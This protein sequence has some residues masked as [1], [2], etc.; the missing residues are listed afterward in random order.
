V[1]NITLTLPTLLLSILFLSACS[2][3]P[4]S[5]Q[6]TPQLDTNSI[7]AQVESEQKWLLDSQDLRTA[8]YLIAISS[9]DDV[10]TL[11]TNQ[12]ALVQW[13]NKH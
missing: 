1:K 8:R 5:L 7:T 9:G 13:L 11:L 12:A 10:A 2:N 4:S 3:T 6:L